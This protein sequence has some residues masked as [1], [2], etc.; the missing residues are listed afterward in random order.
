MMQKEKGLTYKL[1]DLG[2]IMFTHMLPLQDSAH[3]SAGITTLALVRCGEAL[4]GADGAE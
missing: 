3:V 2:R 4:Q 1:E